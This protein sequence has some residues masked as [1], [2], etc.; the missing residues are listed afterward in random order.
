MPR[1]WLDSSI[2]PSSIIIITQKSPQRARWFRFCRGLHATSLPPLQGAKA[3]VWHRWG[4]FWLG[5]L[6]FEGEW[7]VIPSTAAQWGPSLNYFWL[8]AAFYTGPPHLSSRE[9]LPAHSPFLLEG[10]AYTNPPCRMLHLP[11]FLLESPNSP[12]CPSRN[13]HCTTQAKV[14][15]QSHQP[16]MLGGHQTMPALG[17]H[18]P[19]D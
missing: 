7:E 1:L 12:N 16:S 10:L 5:K 15:T 8:K 18:D 17:L 2:L 6:S 13:F 14:A 9:V 11:L 19:E 3:W 4:W